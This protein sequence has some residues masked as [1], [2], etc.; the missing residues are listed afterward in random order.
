MEIRELLLLCIEK[1]ASDL[2]LTEKEPPILRI[3][4]KLHRTMHSPLDR[5]DLKKMIY[6]IYATAR[7]TKTFS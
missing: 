3:D 2:H 6:S 1:K 7:I 5:Q 4:G